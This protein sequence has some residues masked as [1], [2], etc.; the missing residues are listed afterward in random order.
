MSTEAE[1]LKAELPTR[2]SSKQRLKNTLIFHLV[3]ALFGVIERMPLSMSRVFLKGLAGLGYHL[4]KRERVRSIQQLEQ[5]LEGCGRSQAESITRGMFS[6]LGELAAEL[7]NTDA[8]LTHH[9]DLRLSSEHRALFEEALSEGRGVIAVTGHIGNWE[10]LAQLLA[11]EGFDLTSVARPTYDPRLT[12]WVHQ[13]RSAHGMRILWRG[14]RDSPKELL[15]VF[16]NNAILGLLIDQDTRVH[17]EFVPFFGKLA[18]TPSAASSLSLRLDAPIIVG[19]LHRTESGYRLH[20][21]RHQFEPT[22]DRQADIKT[23]TAQLTERLESA[24][25]QAPEQ[26]VWLHNRW[27]T[28]PPEL[29]EAPEEE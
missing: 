24:I 8:L 3:R 22:D 27:K 6:H 26:W 1:I 5:S 4:A 7:A 14:E 17:G 13:R 15:R 10:L 18:F 29:H 20:F 2:W 19:W 12:K 28:R 16:R 23:L 11:R 25:R 9:P 21:E